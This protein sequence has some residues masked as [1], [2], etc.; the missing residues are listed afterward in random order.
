[1]LA[2][3]KKRRQD[4]LEKRIYE[5][6]E[7]SLDEAG[8]RTVSLKLLEIYRGGFRHSYSSFFPIII[9]INKEDNQYNKDYLAD[10]LVRISE[11]VEDDFV[12]GRKEFEHIYDPLHKLCDNLNTEI[13]RWSHYSKYEQK[14]EDIKSEIASLN[15]SMSGATEELK[16]ASKQAASIQTELIAVLSI[17]SAIVV[18]FSGGFSF[19]GSVMTSINGAIYYEAVVLEAIICGMVIFNTIFLL[20]YMVGKI[21]ERNIY[22]SCNSKDCSCTKRCGGLTRIRKRLPYVF[23]FNVICIVGI[24]INFA[25]WGTDIFI[26]FN[27]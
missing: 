16:R 7:K 2:E 22:A 25:V 20:M 21:T 15:I 9:E 4:A 10:N 27:M 8:I 14:V 13:A 26:R 17:F 6:S 3:E 12:S 11:F 18:T 24:F 23:W 5:L 1:M 19:L